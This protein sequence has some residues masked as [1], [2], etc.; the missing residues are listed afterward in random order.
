[1]S[2]SAFTR[3]LTL[4]CLFFSINAV[5]KGGTAMRL[6]AQILWTLVTAAQ[7]EQE[8]NE[9]FIQKP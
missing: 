6:F 1:M 9:H 4:V 2:V 8:I 3:A 7:H 5:V